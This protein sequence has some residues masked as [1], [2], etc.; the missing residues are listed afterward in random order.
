M[1]VIALSSNSSLAL[2]FLL[3]DRTGA[4]WN[5][6]HDST[7]RGKPW[8]G[9]EWPSKRW[10]EQAWGVHWWASEDGDNSRFWEGFGKGWLAGYT[11]ALTN[12]TLETNTHATDGNVPLRQNNRKKVSAEK[13][14]LK[15]AE[16]EAN[17]P[18]DKSVRPL[19]E[20]YLGK[21]SGWALYP[22]PIQIKIRKKLESNSLEKAEDIMYEWELPKGGYMYQYKL[23][24]L[25]QEHARDTAKKFE[26]DE[27]TCVGVQVRMDN[28]KT[29]PIKRW[30]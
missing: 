30:D 12:T 15:E 20:V 14:A 8:G 17:P 24:L 18:A 9:D 22:E 23:Q 19:F 21:K 7:W 3:M 5:P 29:R 11:A 1:L 26:C 13:A 6:K 28:G 4:N 2:I 25:P 16:K 27:S 10:N